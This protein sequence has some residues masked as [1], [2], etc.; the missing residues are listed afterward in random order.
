M[1][2]ADVTEIWIDDPPAPGARASG[3]PIEERF[4]PLPDAEVEV[5][6]EPAPDTSRPSAREA[7]TAPSIELQQADTLETASRPDAAPQP[8]ESD[9]P[10]PE[11]MR[12]PVPVRPA[13]VDATPPATRTGTG[14]AVAR[15]RRPDATPRRPGVGAMRWLLGGVVVLLGF[16]TY[17]SL[18][19]P[20]RT[21]P[22]ARNTGQTSV[23]ATT[24]GELQTRTARSRSGALRLDAAGGAAVL[25]SQ[26]TLRSSRLPILTVAGPVTVVTTTDDGPRRVVTLDGTAVPELRDD[27]ISFAHRAAYPDR[28]V[29]VGFTSCHGHAPPCGW[30]RPFWLVVRAG[31]APAVLKIPGLWASSS[32][33]ETSAADDGVRVDL[34]VWDGERRLATLTAAGEIE[35]ARTPAPARALSRDGCRTVIR[36]LDACAAGRQC[37]TFQDA[38]LSIPRT[39]RDV[40]ARTYHESTG[41]DAGA[42]RGGCIRTCQLGLTPSEGFIRRTVCSGARPGQWSADDS[43]TGFFE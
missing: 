19:T 25:Q 16:Y 33:G 35:V 32:A 21:D 26:E 29:L 2:A 41:F 34:G 38:S 22:T 28:E 40:L 6:L 7:S 10:R 11:A 27:E 14:R 31:L 24:R 15:P 1:A 39:Q 3:F 36:A 13:R 20:A 17:L 30:R 5:L 12:L 43:A 37:R 9:P 8:A 4:E 23:P 42:F 18:R